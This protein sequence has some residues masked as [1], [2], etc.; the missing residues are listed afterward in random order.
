MIT[1]QLLQPNNC[2]GKLAQQIKNPLGGNANGWK[3]PHKSWTW[4]VPIVAQWLMN[5]TRN[6]EVSDLNPGLAQWV[7]DPALWCA[8]VYIADAARIPPCCCSGIGSQLRLRLDP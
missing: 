6:R 5:P 2:K 1:S 4:G 3:N 8:V 7:K